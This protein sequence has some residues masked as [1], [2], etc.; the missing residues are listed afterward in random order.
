M[1][2]KT[3]RDALLLVLAAC[4]G[5]LDAV[6][7]LRLH[8]FSANMTGNTVLFGL[9]LGGEQLPLAP[10]LVALAGFALGSFFGTLLAREASESDPWP[11]QTAQAFALEVVL[12]VAYALGWDRLPHGQTRVLAL[13][14]LAS[15]GMGVQ[16]GIAYDIHT[17]E[18]TTSPTGTLARVFEYAAN[19]LRFGIRGGIAINASTWMLYLAAAAAVGLLGARAVT[20]SVVAW[21]VVAVVIAVA[22]AGRPLV[23]VAA[24]RS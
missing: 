13:L 4:G 14:A 11:A 8:A 3:V 19:T 9:S 20:L 10:P 2:P 23:L 7:Y 22:A 17:P 6:C 12:L 15:M 1:E 21:T 18:S 16:T 24:R 5:A